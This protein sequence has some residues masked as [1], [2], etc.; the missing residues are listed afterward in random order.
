MSLIKHLCLVYF[1]FLSSNYFKY[2]KK[3]VFLFHPPNIVTQ[4]ELLTLY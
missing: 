3:Y 1:C 2:A 4:N